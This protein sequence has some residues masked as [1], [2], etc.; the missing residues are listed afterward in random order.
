MA[1]SFS[2]KTGRQ[3]AMW[4]A[5]QAANQN[6]QLDA[7]AKQGRDAQSKILAPSFNKAAGFLQN[8]YGQ[9]MGQLNAGYDKGIGSLQTMQGQQVGAVNQGY[10]A[11]LNSLQQGYG[12]AA[13]QWQPINQQ[14]MAGYGMYQNALGLG[15]QAGHDAATN[16]FQAGPGYQWNVDQATTQA[17]RAANKVGGLYSGNTVDQTTRLASNLANQEYDKWVNNLQGFQGAAMNSTGALANIYADQGKGSAALQ[18]GQADALSGIYGTSGQQIA[19]AQIGQGQQQASMTSEYG[20]N[21]SGLE[22]ARGNAMAGLQGQYYGNL[23][24]NLNQQYQTLIPAGQQGFQAGQEARKNIN[25]AVMGGIQMAA[26][27]LGG[28]IGG[29]AAGA[30]TSGMGGGAGAGGGGGFLSS[31]FGK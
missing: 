22:L 29:M 1:S 24:N 13:D 4:T 2:G 28:P 17:Q 23:A 5:T 31:L 11:A 7:Y 30:L 14:N 12:Q 10:G 8:T 15:G 3:T 16:A 25:G 20:Q 6:K 21:R 26:G 18:T 27:I 9:G 19:N